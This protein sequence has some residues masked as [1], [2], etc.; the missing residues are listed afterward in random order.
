MTIAV[1][2]ITIKQESVS[3][4]TAPSTSSSGESNVL[5]IPVVA[6]GL[7]HQPVSPYKMI[8]IPSNF[9][10]FFIRRP[11]VPLDTRVA[12]T[13]PQTKPMSEAMAHGIDAVTD[14]AGSLC[15]TPIRNRP[16]QLAPEIPDI[17]VD[18]LTCCRIACRHWCTFCQTERRGRPITCCARNSHA[19]CAFMQENMT[20]S[21]I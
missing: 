21:F 2:T 7:V 6:V 14:R 3:F 18:L 1:T 16:L 9:V 20:V 12:G 13:L 17:T 4:T 19:T 10:V 15:E 11:E 5:R 8:F